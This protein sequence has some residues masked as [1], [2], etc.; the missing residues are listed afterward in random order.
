MKDR[1]LDNI[2][3]EALAQDAGFKSK[4]TFN[5]AFKKQKGLTPTEWRDNHN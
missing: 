3:I 2:K 4:S 1:K 5:V